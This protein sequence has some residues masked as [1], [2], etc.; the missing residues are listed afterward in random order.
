MKNKIQNSFLLLLI[1]LGTVTRM[2]ADVNEVRYREAYIKRLN[3]DVAREEERLRWNKQG[4]L[5]AEMEKKHKQDPSK[6]ELDLGR[7]YWQ[8]DLARR[9]MV[10]NRA[11]I[12]MEVRQRLAL[13]ELK[14]FE[15][16]KR[17]EATRLKVALEYAAIDAIRNMN[18]LRDV[19]QAQ[20]AAMYVHLEERCREAG[21]GLNVS[22]VHVALQSDQ[23]GINAAFINEH[24]PQLWKAYARSEYAQKFV[25][26]V[27]SAKE[28]NVN[29]VAVITRLQK[30]GAAL[31]RASLE[32]LVAFVKPQLEGENPTKSFWSNE[33][34]VKS[35]QPFLDRL[36]NAVEAFRL[37]EEAARQA[38]QKKAFWP[39]DKK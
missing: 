22:D 18:L 9:E 34:K 31:N 24:N 8:E 38:E 7:L 30:D 17:D 11:V 29:A 33:T 15:G 16:G 23:A 3:E 28:L 20:S 32:K 39:E 13:V 2:A 37:E 36:S 21:R 5:R 35:L 12:A 10:R 25:D 6:Y 27:T 1:G 14:K 26:G 4:E 19:A